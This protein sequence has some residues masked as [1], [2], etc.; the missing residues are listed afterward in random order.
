M[1][2]GRNGRRLRSTTELTGEADYPIGGAFRL[3]DGEAGYFFLPFLR[4]FFRRRYSCNSCRVMGRFL[5]L[6]FFS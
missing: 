5:L 3:T 6:A 4:P 1:D 2:Q